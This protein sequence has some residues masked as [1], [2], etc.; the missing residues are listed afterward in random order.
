L[1]VGNQ[2]FN[3]FRF[4][5]ASGWGVTGARLWIV[6]G[7][8]GESGKGAQKQAPAEYQMR[9]YL[10]VAVSGLDAFFLSAENC[11]A[12]GQDP[13]ASGSILRTVGSQLL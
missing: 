8:D 12:P 6:A 2:A 10:G 9:L 13:L 7:L 5:R 1:P 3:G 4:F 11:L